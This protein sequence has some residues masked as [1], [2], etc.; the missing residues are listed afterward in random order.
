MYIYANIIAYNIIQCVPKVPNTQGFRG[1][2]IYLNFVFQL[3][4]IINVGTWVSH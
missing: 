4:S 3:L 1:K 2:S